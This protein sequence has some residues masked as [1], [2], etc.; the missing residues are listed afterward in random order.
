MPDFSFLD[1]AITLL[2]AQAILGALDT[3]GN[4]GTDHDSLLER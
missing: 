2:I 3:L 1:W 4:L